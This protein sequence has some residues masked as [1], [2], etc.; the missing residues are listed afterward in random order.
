MDQPKLVT[1]FDLLHDGCTPAQLASAVEKHG[2]SGWDRFGRFGQFKPTSDGARSALDTLADY[3]SAL[4]DAYER[5][6]QELANLAPGDPYPGLD[7]PLDLLTEHTH[8]VPLH[9]FG[10][11]RDK[12]PPIDRTVQHPPPPTRKISSRSADEILN[13]LGGLLLVLR[14]LNKSG[15]TMMM[16]SEAA[17]IKKV[18]EKY[19]RFPGLSE[20]NLINKF[21]A[22]KQSVETDAPLYEK[23]KISP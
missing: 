5:A 18:V 1:L 21:A 14:D 23:T 15:K 17:L 9:H 13:V 4:N 20:S 11:P 8:T 22:S 6:D 19:P 7:D 16:P 10:W 12:L 3:H 2:V